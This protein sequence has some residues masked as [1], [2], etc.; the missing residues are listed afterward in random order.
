MKYIDVGGC[1]VAKSEKFP[2]NLEAVLI[3][4]IN[5]QFSSS[6]LR[7]PVVSRKTFRWC[8]GFHQGCFKDT[9]NVDYFHHNLYANAAADWHLVSLAFSF[10]S[11]PAQ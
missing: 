9:T 5:V 11:K 4:C 10:K 6:T 1:N 2:L 8:F 3:F 7:L